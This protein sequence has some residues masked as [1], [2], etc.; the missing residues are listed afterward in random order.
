MSEELKVFGKTYSG[1]TGIQAKDTDGNIIE[2][3]SGGGIKYTRYTLTGDVTAGDFI[4]SINYQVQNNNTFILIR[5]SGDAAPSLGNYTL[6]NFV[7]MFL[8]GTRMYA[9]Q[10]WQSGH[11]TPNSFTSLPYT[12]ENIST[13]EI[14][15][16]IL[17]YTGTSTSGIGTTGDVVTIG[18]IPLDYDNTIMEGGAI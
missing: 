2:Y 10:M 5:I 12:N 9:R 1:V 3:K 16:G 6:N 14:Q 18:E 8:D 15:N 11:Q 4:N 13:F 17:V 7:L